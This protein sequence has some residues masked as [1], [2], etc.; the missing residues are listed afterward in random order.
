MNAAPAR[1]APVL[2]E[3]TLGYR[4]Q[5]YRYLA[6]GF[7]Y[8]GP[9]SEDLLRTPPPAVAVDELRRIAPA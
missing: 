7:R 2:D 8:P 4:A 9:E 5:F 6:D 3:T 1:T